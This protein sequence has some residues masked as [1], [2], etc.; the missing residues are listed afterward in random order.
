MTANKQIVWDQ[1]EK[2]KTRVC[3][4]LACLAQIEVVHWTLGGVVEYQGRRGNN[5]WNVYVY[6][7]PKHPMF[8]AFSAADVDTYEITR[9]MPL[10]G[11]QTYFERHFNEAAEVTSVQVGCD[12]G[13]YGDEMYSQFAT[14]DDARLVFSDAEDLFAWAK[15]EAA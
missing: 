1:Q 12:Y 6:L 5:H 3:E 7:Y 13:H 9:D 14:K 15:G 10:H 8:A 2:W 11:G 4:G